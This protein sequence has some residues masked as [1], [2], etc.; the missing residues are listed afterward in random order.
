MGRLDN[1][2][3]LITGALSGIGLATAKRA[4]KENA[5]TVIL[6]DDKV[7]KAKEVLD[8]LG[9]RC[10]FLK[11]DVRSETDWENALIHVKEEYGHLEVLINNAGIT[12]TKFE[13]FSPDLENTSLKNWREIHKVNLDGVFL[14]CK[15]FMPLLIESKNSS[16]VII[17]SRSAL[18]ARKDRIAYGS[19]KSALSNLNRSI[20]MHGSSDNRQ[21]RC[22]MVLPSTIDTAIYNTS[23]QAHEALK[24][25]IP[26]QR[27]GSAEEVANAIVFLA[28]DEASYITGTSL[29]V[30]G[31]SSAQD[32]LRSN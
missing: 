29:V 13:D 21:V 15:T 17:G 10:R 23:N 1:K 14:G 2:N 20:A 9:E 7:E 18:F 6:T 12:G 22:N 19:S 3:I 16:I 24:N 27:F 30:D 25:K 4:I 32:T 26:L 5:K 28:S 31:G 11:L 8:E